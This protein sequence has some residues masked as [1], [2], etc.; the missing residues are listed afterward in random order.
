M[1]YVWADTKLSSNYALIID[2]FGYNEVSLLAAE[3]ALCSALPCMRVIMIYTNT[4]ISH[5]DIRL[6]RGVTT[7]VRILSRQRHYNISVV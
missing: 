4:P 6:I 2:H 7:N 1:A 5:S 3:I